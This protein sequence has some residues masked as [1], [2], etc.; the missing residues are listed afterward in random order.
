MSVTVYR[1]G[2]RRR[3]TAPRLSFGSWAFSFGPFRDAPWTFDRTAQWV[4]DAGYDG[5][6]I[7]GFR[8]HPHDEDYASDVQADRLS[9]RLAELGL[10]ISGYAPDFT[11]TPPAEVA[12]GTYLA[13][14]DS[15]LAFCRRLGITTVRTDTV[16]PPTNR[17]AG[18]SDERRQ[19]LVQAW[20]TGA[21]RCAD[22][23][24][25][26]VWEFEPGFW[27]N[28]P[29]DVRNLLQDIDHQNFGVLFDTSH[30]YT[31]AVA[32]ARHGDNPELLPGG[33]VE[34]AGMLQ[35]W[36]SHLHLIDNDGSLHDEATSAHLPFGM[37]QLDFD[38]VLEA[39]APRAAALPWWTV[40]FCF[41][42][43][44]STDGVTAVRTVRDLIARHAS[45]APEITA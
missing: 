8:P 22:S 35:P 21:Q 5:I 17:P 18:E 26:L 38:G 10:G 25:R 40:D 6:E 32:G 4:A 28:R 43:T 39:L 1:G 24:V 36:L 33:A 34:Y 12:L 3:I 15:V 20:R 42:P 7:N 29:S 27:V 11:G 19:R 45:P 9:S 41:C 14:L 37:G 16:S 23:G 2:L 31:G 44:T 13:R 30:A